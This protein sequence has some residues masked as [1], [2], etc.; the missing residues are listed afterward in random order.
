[1]LRKVSVGLAALAAVG[2]A[3]PAMAACPV[4]HQIDNKNYCVDI[5]VEVHPEVSLWA[6]HADVNLDLEGNNIENSDAFQSVLNHI[7]NVAADITAT[8]NGTSAFPAPLPPQGEQVIFYL[9]D[10]QTA[11][12]AI[13][14][15]A[16]NANAPAGGLRWDRNNDG[17]TQPVVTV[18]VSQQVSNRI[19]T[20][21]AAAPNTLPL[22]ANW[23]LE[24]LWTIAPDS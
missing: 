5:N 6:N 13:A 20:Y 24:L 19:V 3:G 18:P 16:A 15:I 2:F 12:G 1:M 22:P 23:N 7:N 17:A 21:A 8:V 9:F 10:N 4:N 14:A 11:A